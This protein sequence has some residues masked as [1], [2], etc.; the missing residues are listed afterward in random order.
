MRT[1]QPTLLAEPNARISDN[2][3]FQDY[4][5]YNGLQERIHQ[6]NERGVPVRDYRLSKAQCWLDVSLHEYSRNDRSDFPQAAMTESE[7]LIISLEQ[8]SPVIPLD[9]PL[10]NGAARL[11]PDLWARTAEL[12][13]MVGAQCGWPQLA[14]AEVELVHAGNEFN[15]QGWRHAKP[16]IQIAEDWVSDGSVAIASCSAPPESPAASVV[17]RP[18]SPAPDAPT[19]V[20]AP[21][22]PEPLA[23]ALTAQVLF[24]FDQ[25]SA[26]HIRAASLEK[27]QTLLS[28]VREEGVQVQSLELVGYADRLNGTGHA[29]YNQQLSWKRVETVRTLLQ[30]R[31]L[32]VSDVRT[33]AKGDEKQVAACQ[34]QFSRR[35]ELQECLLPNRRVE[36]LLK[37]VRRADGR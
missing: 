25:S 16:Y 21:A 9:T 17:Q 34:A 11:R 7:K 27:L 32:V 12:H 23:V 2:V 33:D 10:V 20:P 22:S 18:A 31:G 35:S 36:V 28:R 24:D 3:I 14:C 26:A 15:Q 5:A 29:E 19:P 8:G 6:L 4:G 1:G 13:R 37:G 30:S